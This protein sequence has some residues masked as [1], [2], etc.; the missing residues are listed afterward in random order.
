[1]DRALRIARSINAFVSSLLMCSFLP[2]IEGASS[3]DLSS[4]TG[5][6]VS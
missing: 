2:V 1:M 4:P 3:L 6:W 5:F